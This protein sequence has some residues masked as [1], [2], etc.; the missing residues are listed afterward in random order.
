M[1]GATAIL[2]PQLGQAMEFGTIVEWLAEEGETV[3]VGQAVAT[4]ESDKAAYEIEAAAA[5]ALRRIAR[6]GAEVPVGAVIG[7]IGGEA[8]ATA[9]PAPVAAGRPPASPK[10]R[11]LA[12]ERGI[13]LATIASADGRLVIARD[14]ENAAPATS[15]PSLKRGAAARLSR[16]WQQAPHFV[17]MV[18]VDASSLSRALAAIRAGRLSCSLNDIFIKAIADTLAR[19]PDINARYVDGRIVPIAGIDIG[20]AVATDGGLDVPVL[21]GAAALPLAG[22]A[23]ASRALIAAARAGGLD[24]SQRGP[25][26]L[27]ISNLGQY[28]ILFGTPVLNLDEPILVFVGAIE[29][30]PVGVDGAVR[31]RPTMTL[32]L[33]FDHR[34]VDGLRAAQFSQAVKQG[35][36]ALEGVPIGDGPAP[37]GERA[38]RAVAGRE[39]FLVTVESRAHRW[40]IDEPATVGGGDFGPDPVTAMLGSLLSC[41]IIALKFAAARRKIVL[42]HVEGGVSATPAA[43]KVK[44]IELALEVRGAASQAELEK[45]LPAARA[46]CLVHDL[47]KA[48][49]AI[50]VRLVAAPAL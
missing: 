40:T 44:R 37:L 7:M 4:L 49:L 25:G 41:M 30:R 38:L 16:S 15:A 20:L 14:L 28:G 22:I 31:L 17:Q 33:C 23:D 13:D 10:A 35:L 11:A 12:R 8:P 34:V 9:P 19:F 5:G 21:R 46:S 32:S 50:D 27:T 1:S 36:E 39:D 29:D 43:G 26:S 3:A 45:L 42:G 47:L 48:E 6:V 18:E 2:M 24:P